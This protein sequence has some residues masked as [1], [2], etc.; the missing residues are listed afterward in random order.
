MTDT[1]TREVAELEELLS[2]KIPCGGNIWPVTRPCPHDAEAVVI[3]RHYVHCLGMMQGLKCS[4]CRDEWMLAFIAK[5]GDEDCHCNT[6]G[7][8]YP[9]NMAYVPL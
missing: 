6:C 7:A 5:Y 1:I 8:F 2:A 3:N 4:L 9:T